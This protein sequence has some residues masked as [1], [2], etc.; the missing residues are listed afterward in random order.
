MEELGVRKYIKRVAGTSVGALFAAMVAVG[1]SS[2]DLFRYCFVESDF[3]AV[4]FENRFG[5]AGFV[6]AL[7]RL[8]YRY[9]YSPGERL[10][11]WIGEMIRKKTGSPDTVSRCI[12]ARGRKR[13][14]WEWEW[15]GKRRRRKVLSI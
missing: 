2:E 14:E 3:Q 10:Y 8:W 5:P 15:E 13:R 9:G 4:M 11:E 1:Y 12:D 6:G 7:V